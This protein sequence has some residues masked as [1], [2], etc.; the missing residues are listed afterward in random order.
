MNF[1]GSRFK[2][3]P[4]M[5]GEKMSHETRVISVIKCTHPIDIQQIHTDYSARAYRRDPHYP[6]H[7]GLID[8][9]CRFIRDAVKG[10]H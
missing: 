6:S 5:V 7:D 1:S 4:F 2:L 10:V 8:T 9:A 3:Y